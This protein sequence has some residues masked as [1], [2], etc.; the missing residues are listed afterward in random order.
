MNKVALDFLQI[1]HHFK[2]LISLKS[3][4]LDST[5]F[6]NSYIVNHKFNQTG[7]ILVEQVWSC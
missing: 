1:L 5:K 7:N 4:I 3:L 6:V 2:S